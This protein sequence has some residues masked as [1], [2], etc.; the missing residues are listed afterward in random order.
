MID[1]YHSLIHNG[2]FLKRMEQKFFL[3]P[4][5][6]PRAYALL[7]QI[8]IPDNLYPNE[9][10]NSLYFDTADLDEHEASCSGDLRK[11]KIRIRWYHTLDRYNG[12]VP[13][14]L[15]LKSRDGFASNKQRQL[16][17]VSRECLAERNIHR[18][19]VPPHMLAATLAQFGH[20]PDKQLKPAILISYWRDRFIEP[21][22]GLRVA[23]DYRIHSSM[24]DCRY[25][26]GGI[27]LAGGVIE[28]KGRSLE[29]PL[30][31]KRMRL[32]DI[33]WSRF[34][35]YS[36]CIEAHLSGP[37]EGR[38]WPSGKNCPE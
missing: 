18:G 32:L 35:K 21:L 34:S 7:R 37:E 12:S 13:V 3:A 30:T 2:S 19:I 6:I 25:A 36:S 14:F 23:L 24:V 27:T 20:Y 9:L 22:S 38:L 10:I 16:T 1:I 8:C 15:E 33:A 5:D 26:N 31:L 11:R 28:L 17:Q 4:Q 29:L